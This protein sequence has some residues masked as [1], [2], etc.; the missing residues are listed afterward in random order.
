MAPKKAA[1]NSFDQ[2]AGHEFGHHLLDSIAVPQ[3]RMNVLFAALFLT[4]AGVF[5]AGNLL[6]LTLPVLLRSAGVACAGAALLLVFYASSRT[7][8]NITWGLVTT[9]GLMWLIVRI[10]Q[11]WLMVFTYLVAAGA[12]VK[13]FRG[14]NSLLR[15]HWGSLLLMAAIATASILG[16]G[17]A[18]TSFDLLE[19]LQA[20]EVTQ[21]TLFHAS[22]AAMI[23]NYGVCSTGLSGLV[24]TPYHVFSHILL[25]GISRLSGT[26]VFE[27]YGIA[28]WIF[29]APLLIF[30]VSASCAMVD[31]AGLASL[32]VLWG[33]TCVVLNVSPMLLGR[34]CAWDSYFVSESYLVSLG[35]FL[36]GLALLFKRE[37]ARS[38]LLLLLVVA[39][40]ISASKASVG[41]I[42]AGLWISRMVFIRRGG[43]AREMVAVSFAVAASAYF[44]AGPAQ[45]VAG[46]IG[47]QPLHFI[48]TYS[49]LGNHITPGME[50]LSNGGG[51]A[52]K[53]LLF[54]AISI[55]GFMAFHFLNVWIVLLD[56]ALKKGCLGLRSSPAA[57]YAFSSF[58]AGF[59]A[60][61]FLSV[62]GGSAYYFSNVSFFAA[63]PP[64]V[65][66]PP[67]MGP[68]S[69]GGL[70]CPGD[71]LGIDRP[72]Q[73][74]GLPPPRRA[75]SNS[76][77]AGG[78]RMY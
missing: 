4:L 18:L 62:H 63:L 61:F 59:L 66:Y 38:D 15:Q 24:E 76:G 25:A 50:K 49:H 48:A 55:A 44:M 20:G 51:G 54:A 69:M 58:V 40:M 11:G 34:W 9:Y 14:F 31:R 41:L 13:Y 6:L 57:V 78:G 1:M 16:V 22:L 36:L 74:Q 64:V 67:R 70:A 43:L 65:M 33:A 71:G 26:G 29:F 10:G 72:A 68:P 35:L 52:W 8:G 73:H 3:A 60:V 7:L 27:V 23:K 21:D 2:M 46:D 56:T 39:A 12:L 47:F 19:R 5:L 32:P 17:G 53:S 45:G 77:K 28:P 37:L 42:Y 30:S 75:S